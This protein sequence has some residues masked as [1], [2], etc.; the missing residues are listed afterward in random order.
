MHT[1]FLV[2][3]DLIDYALSP[4]ACNPMAYQPCGDYSQ[5]C[6]LQGGTYCVDEANI[7][8]RFAL[9]CYLR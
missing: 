3:L 4:E 7:M 5:S 2:R 6:A 1:F 8:W 9:G